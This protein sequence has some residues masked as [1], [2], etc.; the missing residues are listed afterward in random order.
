[1]LLAATLASLAGARP[2]YRFDEK[3]QSCR[4]LKDGQLEWDSRGYGEGGKIFR[5]LCK[6]CH[7]RDNDQ[8][9]PFLW[10]ESKTS[11]AWN[12]VFTERYPKCA[13]NGAWDSATAEELRKVNDYLY[14]FSE[15]SRDKFDNC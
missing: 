7:S 1:M 15:N 6:K 3:T 11:E 8:N 10:N 14:R 4:N 13:K 5:D 9:A 2:E 12:R